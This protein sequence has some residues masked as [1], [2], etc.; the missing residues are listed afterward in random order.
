MKGRVLTFAGAMCALLLFATMFLRSYRGFDVNQ[1]VSRPTTQDRGDN[2]Y[3]GAMQWL[4]AEHIRSDRPEAGS[5]G[6]I[7]IVTLPVTTRYQP[8]EFR[9]LDK[10]VREGNTLLVLAAL[11]DQPD[12][13]YAMAAH[14]AGDLD[15][16]TGLQFQ[17]T[18]AGS[19]LTAHFIE[20]QRAHLVP[21]RPHA[22]FSKVTDV[23][24]LSDFSRQVWRVSIPPDGFVLS[25]AHDRDTREGVLWTRAVG[26]GRIVVSTFGSLFTNR[27][28]GLADNAQLFANLVGAN[29]GPQGRVLFDDVHQGLSAEYDPEKFFRD[30][31][32]YY[33][34]GILAA[35]WLSWVLGSTKLTMPVARVPAP[36]EMELIRATGGFLSR[37]L[38]S[39]VGAR[40]ILDLFLRRVT[41]HVPRTRDSAADPWK[42]LERRVAAA[43]LR[44]LQ[45]WSGDAAAAR[46]VPL[47]RLQ[48][49]ILRIERQLAQ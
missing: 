19:R 4:A 7:L 22:Y 5:V 27:A 20:P 45:D 35:L 28:L 34:L 49:L 2:G 16:L 15:L 32:L 30:P 29:L 6:N 21:N 48:N 42:F 3:R 12:W 11:A 14:A 44:Q 13:A 36:R 23:V 43:D 9:A 31:R 40:R 18:Q 39:D 33:T 24:A 8:E 10:W 38:R 25:L 47:S 17:S 26:N 37:V 41:E 46:R 1:A